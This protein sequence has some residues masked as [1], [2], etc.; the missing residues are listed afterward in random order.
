[1]LDALLARAKQDPHALGRLGLIVP[2]E[3]LSGAELDGLDPALVH[4]WKEARAMYMSRIRYLGNELRRAGAVSETMSRALAGLLSAVRAEMADALATAS[5]EFKRDWERENEAEAARWRA[6]YGVDPPRSELDYLRMGRRAGVD[7]ERLLEGNWTPAELHGIIRGY[8]D[9]LRDARAVASTVRPGMK[10]NRVQ[11]EMLA[12]GLLF[13][14]D[15]PNASLR[16]IA[17][18]LGV[19]HTTISRSA[20]A[21]PIRRARRGEVGRQPPGTKYRDP[22]TGLADVEIDPDRFYE[23]EDDGAA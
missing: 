7:P 6:D 8:F 11:L 13:I 3:R 14:Q 15:N 21:G 1:L 12:R 20:W 5:E 19:S 4:Q 2:W 10:R 23:D 18:H 22:E 17:C 9:G 16:D